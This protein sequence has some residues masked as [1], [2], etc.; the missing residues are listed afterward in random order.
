[1]ENIEVPLYYQGR[2]LADHD[3][4]MNEMRELWTA[5]RDFSMFPQLKTH[6]PLVR[7]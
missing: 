6:N 1:V 4:Y 7:R 2:I 5:D 3:G